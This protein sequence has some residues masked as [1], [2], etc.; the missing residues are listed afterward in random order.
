MHVSRAVSKALDADPIDGEYLLEA[1]PRG[2]ARTDEALLATGCGKSDAFVRIAARRRLCF[3]S[4]HRRA[5]QC[6]EIDVDGEA[7][8]IDYQDM[9]KARSRRHFERGSRTPWKSIRTAPRMVDEKGVSLHLADAIEEALLSRVPHL[10]GA[11]SQARI[12]TTRRAG[13]VTV[14]AMDEDEEQPTA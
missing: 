1:L 3:W 8:T 12:E 14:M 4:R 9:R 5:D 11:I 13:R 10:P 7:T 6:N 2:R